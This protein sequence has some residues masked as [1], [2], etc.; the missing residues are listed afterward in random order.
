MKEEEKNGFK[1][2]KKN[3]ISLLRVV[4]IVIISVCILSAS[5]WFL[6]RLRTK[7]DRDNPKNAPGVV[8]NFMNDTNIDVNGKISSS[9][10]IRQLWEEMKNNGNDILQYLDSA[11]ELAKLIHAAQALDFPDTREN[12]DEPID[13]NKID[14]DST[15]IQGIVKFKRALEDGNEIT[16]TYVTPSKLQE[17][18]NKY[19]ETGKEKDKQEALKHFTIEQTATSASGDTSIVENSIGINGAFIFAII[20]YLFSSIFNSYF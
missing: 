5:L 18:M 8:R 20:P 16:M 14:I 17:L 7:E 10:S 19:T 6:K 13:W 1:E 4:I 15:E 9:K 11:E 3:L 12:P 2:A